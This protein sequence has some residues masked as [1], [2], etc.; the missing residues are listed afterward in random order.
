MH[1]LN[2]RASFI[3]LAT[4]VTSVMLSVIFSFYKFY[5]KEDFLIYL[6]AFCDPQKEACFM[7]QC[8]ETDVRCTPLVDGKFYYKIIYRKNLKTPPC[9]GS[10]CIAMECAPKE[11]ECE[12]FYCSAD[13]LVLFDLDDVCDTNL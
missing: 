3:L 5:I 10:S 2:S 8:D 13:N 7:Q 1:S 11:V 4:V 12:T 9:H 6:K